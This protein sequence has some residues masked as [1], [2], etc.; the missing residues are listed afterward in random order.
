[1]TKPGPYSSIQ[2]PHEDT[3]PL[4]RFRQGRSD[5]HGIP[6]TTPAAQA[7]FQGRFAA[8]YQQ[9]NAPIDLC[10]PENS[11]CL[12]F[13]GSGGYRDRDPVLSCYLLEEEGYPP[14][15]CNQ[16]FT[17]PGLSEPA[18]VLVADPTRELVYIADSHRI[19]S[20]YHGEDVQTNAPLP[21]HTLK[22]RQE[23]P[24]MLLEGGS[25]LLRAGRTGID[26]WNVD[27]LP[28]HGPDGDERIGE[29]DFDTDD[30]R[31]EDWRDVELSTGTEAH[32]VI[33]LAR[34]ALEINSWTTVPNGQ[35][36]VGLK[37]RYSCWATDL[38]CGLKPV[39]R[40][41]GHGA[42]MTGFSTSQEDPNCFLTTCKDGVAR[43]Y[44]VREPLP[45]IAFN[46]GRS[47]EILRSALYILVEGLPGTLPKV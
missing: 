42:Y 4:A 31:R 41:L 37:E 14:S 13:I 28:D 11:N 40:Y 36:L 47:K 38:E 3:S 44:D 12:A 22:T 39:T 43:L 45:R 7:L 30:F 21:K 5:W 10:L 23:G 25:K 16:M 26:G 29:G 6:D 32:S 34:E 24:L 27:S 33:R 46:C 8:F 35:V 18:Y 19:K 17:E 9:T 20:F 15:F 1:M 2:R